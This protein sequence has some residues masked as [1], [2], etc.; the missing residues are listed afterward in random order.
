VSRP[1]PFPTHRLL[2]E[3]NP[4]RPINWPKP[5]PRP[6]QGQEAGEAAQIPPPA[7]PA[8]RTFA[9]YHTERDRA[10]HPREVVQQQGAAPL[11][12]CEVIAGI[13][14]VTHLSQKWGD[15]VVDILAPGALIFGDT[16]SLADCS[17]LAATE[18]RL[19]PL[20]GSAA[21]LVS[22]RMSEELVRQRQRRLI[23][24]QAT[25]IERLAFFLLQLATPPFEGG[26]ACHGCL[27]QGS[28]IA[29]PVSRREIG[30]ML[31]LTIETLSRVLAKLRQD[32]VIRMT[33]TNLVTVLDPAA[34]V[35][36]GGDG[37][38]AWRHPVCAAPLGGGGDGLN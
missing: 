23:L 16:T 36:L 31:G 3:Q 30:S 4:L 14:L 27:W 20:A 12:A 9:V 28:T 1:N 18:L 29:I 34:L 17:I 35:A 25:A 33:G 10:F 26:E 2:A 8:C 19:R 22:R 32:G 7:P 6:A 5:P 13:A 24:S 11:E 21:D 38:V 37:S 15:S